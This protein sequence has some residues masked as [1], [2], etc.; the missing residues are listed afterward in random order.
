MKKMVFALLT[1]VL[2]ATTP[3][4]LAAD[5]LLCAPA[6]KGDLEQVYALIAAG[7]AEVDAVN[8]RGYTPLILAAAANHP[9]V[10]GALLRHEAEAD[11]LTKTGRTEVT[12]LM[13]ASLRG[14]TEVVRLLLQNGA[15]PNAA[16]QKGNTAMA[17]AVSKKHTEIIELLRAGGGTPIKG[18]TE[19]ESTPEITGFLPSPS[20][21]AIIFFAVIVLLVIYLLFSVLHRKKE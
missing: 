14:H 1:S 5:C 13:V 16:N 21:A 9:D 12:A 10:V 8:D 20:V 11:G 2:L 15:S 19:S 3:S 17:F 6:Q 4:V 18:A 7:V